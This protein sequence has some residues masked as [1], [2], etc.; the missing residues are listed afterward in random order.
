VHDL[1]ISKMA[2][3]REKDFSF[4]ETMLRKKYVS[5][6]TLRERLKG[7]TVLKKESR[8]VIL[9]RLDRWDQRQ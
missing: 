4:V 9:G 7:T 1:A 2:A 3:M 6:A 5:P 8:E